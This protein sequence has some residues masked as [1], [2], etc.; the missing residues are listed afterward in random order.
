MEPSVWD[1]ISGALRLNDETF[2]SLIQSSHVYAL[3]III[4]ALV[5]TSWMLGH[6]AV[7]FL[8]QVPRGRFLVTMI[9]LAAS[10]VLGALI[11]VTSTWLVT[12]LFPGNRNVPLRMVLPITAFA[13]APLVLSILTIIPYVGSG[14][15]AVLNTW[16][17]LTLVLA[18]KVSFEI[19]VLEALVCALL[20]WG[21]TRVLP[22]LAGG[23]MS[24][25]FNN[26][27]YR[28]SATGLRST[29]ESAAAEAVG[30]LRGP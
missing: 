20:G 11:W 25:I 14:I 1:V 7:L 23:R 24:L 10:F 12:T 18:V 2:V 6:C 3:S 4:L 29:G 17:L 27:W 9:G 21:L 22:R 5:G 16:S 19:G 28:V 13:Y 15:E 30:R 26:A 8:N